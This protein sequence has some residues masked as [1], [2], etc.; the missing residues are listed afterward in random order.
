MNADPS[1]TQS[2]HDVAYTHFAG[3]NRR[4]R[5]NALA[6]PLEVTR[7]DRRTPDSLYRPGR[8]SSA[9]TLAIRWEESLVYIGIGTVVIIIIIVLVVLA[10]RR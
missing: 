7:L 3:V 4:F 10:L 1:A 9:G 8:G 6:L 2:I 5:G